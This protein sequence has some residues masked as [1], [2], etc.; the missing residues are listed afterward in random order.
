MTFRKGGGGKRR[1]A[2]EAAIVQALEQVG[3]RVTRISGDG[4]P[5]LLVRFRGRLWAFEVKS[6]K[7]S[8]TEAQEVTQWPVIRSVAEALAAL[9]CEVQG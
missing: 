7:G 5:D 2:N 3:A 8:R 1:D 9:G 6:A 4:A